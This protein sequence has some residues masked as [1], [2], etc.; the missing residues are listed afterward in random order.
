[1]KKILRKK[2]EKNKNPDVRDSFGNEKWFY[3]NKVREHF[4]HPKNLLLNEPKLG[5][6][7]AEGEVGNPRCGDVMKMWIKIDPKTQKIKDVKWRTFGCASA[8]AAVSVYST[9]LIEKGGL[10][11][12]KALKITPQD[13]IKKLN[14]LPDRKI[15]C[16]VLAD[17][18]FKQAL[19]NYFQKNKII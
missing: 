5:D 4:F 6:F 2:A 9:M 12:K 18:V 11:I 10:T 8:I 13:V 7:N 14:G 15:H 19:D 16:S 1:M 3:S 17:Q